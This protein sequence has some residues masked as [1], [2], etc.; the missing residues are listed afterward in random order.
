[1]DPEHR[2][3]ET[4]VKEAETF[5]NRRELLAIWAPT[6]IE[7]NEYITNIMIFSDFMPGQ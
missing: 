3:R 4:L 7:D 5:G 6:H 1:V 2:I